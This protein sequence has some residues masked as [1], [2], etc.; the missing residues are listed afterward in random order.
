[1][2]HPTPLLLETIG[3]ASHPGGKRR[4]EKAAGAGPWTSDGLT[5]PEPDVDCGNGGWDRK[6]PALSD[7]RSEYPRETLRPQ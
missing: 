2:S 6:V 3:I 5:D 4:E 1:M 7:V